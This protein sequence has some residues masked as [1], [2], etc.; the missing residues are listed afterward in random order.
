MDLPTFLFTLGLDPP[1]G[2]FRF[3][4]LGRGYTTVFLEH[5]AEV[6]N[7]GKSAFSGYLTDT[8][9]AAAKHI[10][11]LIKPDSCEILTEGLSR[12]LFE[13]GS[14]I[15]CTEPGHFCHVFNGNRL[16]IMLDDVLHHHFDS[17]VHIALIIIAINQL[18]TPCEDQHK[19][20]SC[21]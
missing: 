6:E 11:G 7:V 15:E 4:N 16:S 2:F 5:L 20:R 18:V 9:H 10:L 8:V 19:N 3:K 21:L 13:Q 1:N 12:L 17:T 14:K